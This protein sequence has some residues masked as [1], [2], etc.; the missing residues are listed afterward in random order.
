MTEGLEE[1]M[2]LARRLVSLGRA[3]RSESGVKVRQPLRRALVVLPPD[4]PSL[5]PGV[6][7]EELNVDEIVRTEQMGEIVAYE[8]VPNF[9]LLGPRLGEGGEGG[10]P[11]LG[12]VER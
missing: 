1:E 7:E 9:R 8:L 5:P 2:A 4:S 3:A 11:A 12:R 10:A 6:V